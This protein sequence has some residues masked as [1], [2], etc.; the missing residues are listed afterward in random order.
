MGK[1]KVHVELNADRG[2]AWALQAHPTDPC[3]RLAFRLT[4]PYRPRELITLYPQSDYND[5]PYKGNALV[6][7]LNGDN[8]L[9]VASRPRRFIF[10]HKQQTE[11]PL[12][13]SRFIGGGYTDDPGNYFK[14]F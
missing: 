10:I 14:R 2:K 12:I 13:L 1:A 9:V 3:Y 11:V 5:A 4:F 7:W 6:D 8:D